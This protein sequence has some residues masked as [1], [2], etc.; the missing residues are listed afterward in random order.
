MKVVFVVTKLLIGMK[1]VGS[2]MLISLLIHILI[3]QMIMWKS[4]DSK[5]KTFDLNFYFFY[6]IFDIYFG[7]FPWAGFKLMKKDIKLVERIS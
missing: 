7:F 5:H 3:S 2:V 1:N 6:F 4:F